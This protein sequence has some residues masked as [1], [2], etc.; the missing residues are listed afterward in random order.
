MTTKLPSNRR[1]AL[2]T[3]AGSLIGTAI[4]EKLASEG[5]HLI[6]H[7]QHAKANVSHLAK[8]LR[9]QGISTAVFHADFQS[10]PFDCTSLIQIL[11]QW[12]QL[13]VLINNASVFLKTPCSS[14]EAQ[15]WETIFKINVWAPYFLI[16]KT[17]KFL[18]RG[19]GCIINLTDIYADHPLLKDHVAYCASKAALKN[20]TQSLAVTLGPHIRVNAVAPGGI[21]FPSTYTKTQKKALM[22]K[23]ALK[24]AGTA[25]EIAQ[26]VFSLLSNSFITGQTLRVD[27]G[28]LI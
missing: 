19:S 25:N 12:G 16:H 21:S 15:T 1:V 20:I 27:G 11:K 28:R 18:K 4:S 23:S 6:L 22:E 24:R 14:F 10:V 2:I 8:R 7:Y 26:A 17:L 5:Y 3:G 13:N 9:S